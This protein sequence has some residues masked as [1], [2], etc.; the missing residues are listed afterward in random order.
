M[1]RLDYMVLIFYVTMACT[2]V[3]TQ[4]EG[5]L[6]MHEV[7]RGV[8]REGDVV[9]KEGVALKEYWARPVADQASLLRPFFWGASTSIANVSA[10]GLTNR[11]QKP[12]R[13]TR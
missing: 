7:L 3:L 1:K 12:V 9:V 2:L 4:L 13:C 8:G 6:V 5:C 11:E 10:T